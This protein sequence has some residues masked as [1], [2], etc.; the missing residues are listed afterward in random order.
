MRVLI[1]VLFL[2]LSAVAALLPGSFIFGT[3]IPREFLHLVGYENLLLIAH[4][5]AYG[6][7]VVIAA[8]V[9]GRLV[10][11]ALAVFLF[12][13][14][15]EGVQALI[16]WRE[17]GL[18]DVLLNLAAVLLGILAVLLIRGFQRYLL[19]GIPTSKP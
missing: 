13:L 9:W 11:A 1:L 6:G 2:L 4:L 5:G 8:W 16:P 10:P 12:S 17:G 18:R 7:L 19:P 14:G 15:I 3:L